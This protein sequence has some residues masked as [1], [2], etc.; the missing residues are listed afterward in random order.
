MFLRTLVSRYRE[1][2]SSFN[3]MAADLNQWPDKAKWPSKLTAQ[4][5]ELTHTHINLAVLIRHSLKYK[6]T[7][8]QKTYRDTELQISVLTV[9]ENTSGLQRFQREGK[10][11]G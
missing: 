2:K 4:N 9:N 5:T 11:P 7:V 6:N 3:K 8:S 10:E 1:R